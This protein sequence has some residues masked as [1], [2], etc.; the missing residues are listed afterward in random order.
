MPATV[1]IEN[2]L[3]MGKGLNVT[4]ASTYIVFRRITVL[5]REGYRCTEDGLL[6]TFAVL[7]YYLLLSH[8]KL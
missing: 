5:G 1:T 8:D 4:A 7:L 2:V 6:A 3:G